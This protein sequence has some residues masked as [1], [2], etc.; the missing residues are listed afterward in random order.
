MKHRP[1]MA[2]VAGCFVHVIV[3]MAILACTVAHA[4]SLEISFTY[5]YRTR[6]TPLKR[7]RY[8]GH[9]D[10]HATLYVNGIPQTLSSIGSFAGLIP[11][12]VGKNVLMATAELD[13]STASASLVITRTPPPGPPPTDP[14]KIDRAL[15]LPKAAVWIRP[16]G[17]LPVRCVGSPGGVATFSVGRFTRQPM[18]EI[19]DGIYEGELVIQSGEAYEKEP[20]KFE[21]RSKNRRKRVS[22]T[23]RGSVAILGTGSPII[24]ETASDK[25]VPLY[26]TAKGRTRYVDLPTGVRMEA[27]GRTDRRYEVRLSAVRSAFVDARQVK[28]LSEGTRRPKSTVESITMQVKFDR[29]IVRIPLSQRLPYVVTES[30]DPPG[31]DLRIYGAES[32]TWWITGRHNDRAIKSIQTDVAP[33]GSYQVLLTLWHDHWG[34]LAHYEGTTLCLEVNAPPNLPQISEGN[35]RGLVVAI[36]P[37]HGGTN[38]G[39]RAPS[40]VWEKD[41]N[42][43]LS[44]LLERRIRA[45]GGETVILRQGDEQVSLRDRVERARRSGADILISL[46][47]NSIGDDNDPLA[48]RGTSTYYYHPHSAEPSRIVYETLLSVPGVSPWGHVGQFDF[49]PIRGATDMIGFLV[50][51]VFLSH[52]NDEEIILDAD[53]QEEVTRAIA[54]GLVRFLQHRLNGPAS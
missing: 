22:A 16:P 29:T 3:W 34:Y 32:D 31:L 51:C 4:A 24:L 21:L 37:G 8:A 5:P 49:T 52:P 50:E 48:T 27:I 1:V 36:D 20:I 18:I 30:N 44:T 40:G 43:K 26:R 47:N 23:A 46:H 35:L 15:C 12:A 17:S 11:L 25:P 7:I 13:G 9:T 19:K 53:R 14:W 38:R 2:A 10:P 42:R 39:A 41:I 28:R 45:L 6:T 54:E 33:D